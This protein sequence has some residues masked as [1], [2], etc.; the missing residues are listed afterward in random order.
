MVKN[1][2]Y[3]AKEMF[4]DNNSMMAYKIRQKS[5]AFILSLLKAVF[6]AGVCFIIFYPVLVM[7]SKAVMNRV[8]IFDDSVILIPRH[9]TLLNFKV[10]S[11]LMFYPTALFNSL[12][13]S[14][15]CTILQIASCILAGYA[16]GRYPSRIKNA[17]FILVIVTI[18]IPPQLVMLP[19]FIQF[20]SFDIFGILKHEL[21]HSVNMINTYY[22]FWMLSVTANGCKNGLF[23][24][25]FRQ[26]FRNMPKELEDASMVDGCN[27]FKTFK[28]IMLPNSVT[29]IVTVALFS[30][31]W[32]YNDVIYTR[33]FAP[34]MKV[35][36]MMY[37]NLER[38]TNPVMKYIGMN[39][40]DSSSIL[41]QLYIP[42]LKCA[43]VLM[44][45]APVIVIFLIFQRYFVES[46]ERS[47]IT[48]Q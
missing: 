13:L 32:Q 39:S 12:T 21:G 22:P 27:S 28:N 6:L 5:K 37:V 26:S 2:L 19:L 11:M 43:G 24:F 1:I 16:F 35:L 3:K 14:V 40:S 9:F 4:T 45:L 33:I 23:I 44:I 10:A 47:G 18:I 42:I 38:L 30:F 29:S 36:P 46:I 20:Q 41:I 8:D 31:V 48:G 7:I 25:I 15:S 17:L 34:T